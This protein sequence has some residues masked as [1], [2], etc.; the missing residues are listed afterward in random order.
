MLGNKQSAQRAF[1][2]IEQLSPSRR[3]KNDTIRASLKYCVYLKELPRE[4]LSDEEQEFMKT[5]AQVDAWYDAEISKAE[6]QGKLEGKLEGKSKVSSKLQK[7]L[8]R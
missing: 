1:R 6:L 5:M 7:K 8:S 4:S 2:E 3:E